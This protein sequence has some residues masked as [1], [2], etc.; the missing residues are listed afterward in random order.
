[1]PI[2]RP[3]TREA[4]VKQAI[5]I[6]GRKGTSAVTFQS[7]AT[8]L[9]VSKQAIIYWYPTKWALVADICLPFMREE[10][11]AL[12]PVLAEAGSAQGAI[13]AL[14]RTFVAHYEN[15]LPQFR[16][17][18]LPERLGVSRP[19]SAAQQ[20]ALAPVHAITSLVYK[21]LEDRITADASNYTK[22]SP[23]RAAVAVH[24]AAVGLVTMFAAADALGD[25]MV[26]STDDMV[27]ALVAVLSRP[28]QRV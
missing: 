22:V 11:D 10:A 9:G 28:G 27:D 13:N 18:Y 17:L 8:A 4:I 6:I 15:R 19:N 24:M 26:H 1:M 12:L 2:V 3:V 20:A 14:V 23:R 7:V 25:P 16:M 5:K 21:A